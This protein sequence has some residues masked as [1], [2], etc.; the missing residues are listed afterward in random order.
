MNSTKFIYPQ[1][2]DSIINIHNINKSS[3]NLED[4]IKVYLFYF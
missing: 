2:T 3:I 1:Y 4:S